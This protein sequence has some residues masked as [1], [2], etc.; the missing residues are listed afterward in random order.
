MRTAV[1]P[2][3]LWRIARIGK[4]LGDALVLINGTTWLAFFLCVH[5]LGQAGRL[6]VTSFVALELLV[7]VAETFLIQAA[8]R[9][10]FFV[11]NP[12]LHPVALPQVI[13]IALG[14][15]LVSLLVSAVPVVAIYLS[16]G[17]FPVALHH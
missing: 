14:G 13:R 11:R 1:R 4:L 2:S 8:T 7:V 6:T 16:T 17:R 3:A 5:R 10:Q 15:N 12:Q 9:G